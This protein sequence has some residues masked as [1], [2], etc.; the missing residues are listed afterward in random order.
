MHFNKWP[1]EFAFFV[2]YTIGKDAYIEL[3]ETALAGV[4]KK[5]NWEKELERLSEL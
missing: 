3:R 1:I 2:F 5:M 4:G